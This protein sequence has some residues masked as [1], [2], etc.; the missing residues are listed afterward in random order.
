MI[1]LIGSKCLKF[2]L[3]DLYKLM[4]GGSTIYSP[5]ILRRSSLEIKYYYHGHQSNE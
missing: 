2:Q 4:D 1:F 5:E 3:T